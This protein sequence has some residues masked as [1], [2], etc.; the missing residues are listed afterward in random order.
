LNGGPPKKV[1]FQ[2]EVFHA[3]LQNYDREFSLAW[4]RRLRPSAANE[5]ANVEAKRNA[6]GFGSP[7]LHRLR[8]KRRWQQR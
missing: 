1:V 2:L 7:V 3:R 8:T 4:R 6:K 5:A